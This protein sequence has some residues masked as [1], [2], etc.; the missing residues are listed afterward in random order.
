[1]S[2]EWHPPS[3]K[4]K[5]EKTLSL[6]K[7]YYFIDGTPVLVAKMPESILNELIFISEEYRKIKEHKLSFLYEHCNIG[8]NTFQ[9]SVSKPDFQK[10][11]TFPYLISLGQFYLFAT[12]N[13]SFTDSHRNVL[14][15]E[16]LNHYDGYD[17]WIN[18]T[19]KGDENPSHIHAGDFSGVIY[20]KNTETTPTI[21][22]NE[23]K[24][25]GKPG[26]IVIFPSW[27]EHGVEKK[28]D[29]SER[30]TMSFNLYLELY[31]KNNF[32]LR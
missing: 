24:F 1:M 7:D 12:K 25:P 9:I 22:D 14:I 3:L 27:L 17:F 2:N 19:N 5:E 10:S 18:Y 26:E 6:F 8:L 16:N 13:I 4:N 11:F 30:I 15:R 28:E 32:Y 31:F 29:D 23:V 21:F 20:V